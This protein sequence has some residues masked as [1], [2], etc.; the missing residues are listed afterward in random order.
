MRLRYVM[1]EILKGF[2]HW[3]LPAICVVCDKPALDGG[4]LCEDCKSQ[5]ES[6]RIRAPRCYFCGGPIENGRTCHICKGKRLYFDRIKAPFWYRD[7]AVRVV[8]VF[9]YEKIKALG[10]IMAFQMFQSLNDEFDFDFMAPVPLHSVRRRERG[11]SQ[12]LIL[13][14]E[15]SKLASKPLIQPL[16]RTRNTKSQTKLTRKERMKNVEGAFQL[17]SGGPVVEGKS[18]LLVDDVLTTG[19]TLLEAAKILKAAGAITVYAVVF[20]I[21][22]PSRE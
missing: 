20:A 8:E 15:L 7:V 4:L 21:A 12:T 19:S 6:L 22:A 5:L 11:F 9:K 10:K 13:S 18:I 17:R 3:L 16:L 14:H 2:I 1:Q